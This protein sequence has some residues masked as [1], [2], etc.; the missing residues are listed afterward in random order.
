MAQIFAL[1]DVVDGEEV[2]SFGDEFLSN[3]GSLD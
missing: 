2:N 1:P 3:F